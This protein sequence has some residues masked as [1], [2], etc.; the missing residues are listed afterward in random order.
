MN[1]D[2]KKEILDKLKGRDLVSSPANDKL[3]KELFEKEEAETN[4][5]I[6]KINDLRKKS[7]KPLLSLLI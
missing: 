7:G 6:E 2:R 1:S 5:F 3:Y 4:S